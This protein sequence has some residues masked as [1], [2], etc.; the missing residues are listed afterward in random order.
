MR[1]GLGF[2]GVN[3]KPTYGAEIFEYV[4]QPAPV[5]VNVR[6]N[7]SY[8]V[9]RGPYR[10]VRECLFKSGEVAFDTDDKGEGR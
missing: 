10:G 7:S 3:F 8:V 6:E 9:G 4:N 5:D 2:G 1:G